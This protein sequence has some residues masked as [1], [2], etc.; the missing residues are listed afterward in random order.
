M[1][2]LCERFPVVGEALY[3]IYPLAQEPNEEQRALLHEDSPAADSIRAGGSRGQG[4]DVEKWQYMSE[5]DEITNPI[6]SQDIVDGMLLTGLATGT[7]VEDDH[8]EEVA[9]KSE[10]ED[11]EDEEEE[12]EVQPPRAEPVHLED[13]PNL[14]AAFAGTEKAAAKEDIRVQLRTNIDLDAWNAFCFFIQH[15]LVCVLWYAFKYD[16]A[17]TINPNWT[18]VLG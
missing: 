16:E 17:G 13:T 7:L 3:I 2:K 9:G 11:E 8:L 4:N 10:I 14:E 5:L 18:E 1:I 15:M 6:D 12:K